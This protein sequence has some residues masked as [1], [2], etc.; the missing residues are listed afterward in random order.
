MSNRRIAGGA[1]VLFV[2]MNVI[3]ALA[4]GKPPAF[5]DPIEKLVKFAVEKDSQIVA[6]A[7]VA[8]ISTFFVLVFF[9]GL[10]RILRQAEGGGFDF[11]T[12]FLAG[13]VAT[14]AVAT[15]GT[16]FMALPSFESEQLST[17]PTEQVVRFAN[18]AAGM[19]FVLLGGIAVAV[20]L[21]AALSIFR[22][23]GLPSWLGALGLLG[24]AVEVVGTLG[25]VSD[26]LYKAG[27]ALVF[28]PFMVWV[29]AASV[30]LLASSD[31]ASA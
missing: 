5:D 2:V 12:V 3:A 1:G 13:G 30:T 25:V 20:L 22:S 11:S 7:F 31:S 9:V 27:L 16:A 8:T 21:A 6:G 17:G 29:L 23:R 28:M 19:T 10:W 18:D 14:A 24:A 4:P 15:I 26:N